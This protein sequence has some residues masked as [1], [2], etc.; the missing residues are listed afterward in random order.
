MKRLFTEPGAG[1]K[2]TTEASLDL[3]QCRIGLRGARVMSGFRN[4][5]CWRKLGRGP[6]TSH[7]QPTP[8]REIWGTNTLASMSSTLP[9]LPGPLTNNHRPEVKGFCLVLSIKI[10]CLWAGKKWTQRQ[11]EYPH[12]LLNPGLLGRKLIIPQT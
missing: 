6:E 3:K 2:D 12:R 10:C 11:R 5:N 4:L 7:C 8:N 1:L 9:S